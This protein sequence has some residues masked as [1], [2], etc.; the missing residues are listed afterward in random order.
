MNRQ[1]GQILRLKVPALDPTQPHSIWNAQS[2]LST[3]RQL[4]ARGGHRLREHILADAAGE[5]TQRLLLLADLQASRALGT[6]AGGAL[7]TQ[8]GGALGT[9]AAGHGVRKRA[10]VV[11]DGG[12]LTVSPLLTGQALTWTMRA[13]NH[14][15]G[16]ACMV[17]AGP[18][19]ASL[20]TSH[21]SLSAHPPYPPS[22]GQPLRPWRRPPSSG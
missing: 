3:T 20:C 17:E 21:P 18:H 16:N 11:G 13:R 22:C 15:I 8:A 14:C 7:G 12:E 4:T 5:L 10:G 2:A 6:Q 9:Q 19:C 1:Q